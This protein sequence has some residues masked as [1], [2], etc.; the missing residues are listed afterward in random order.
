MSWLTSKFRALGDRQSWALH[1]EPSFLAP[2]SKLSNRDMDPTPPEKRTWKMVNFTTYWISDTFNVASWDQASA[3]LTLGMSAGQALACIFVGN[4][5]ISWAITATGTIGARHH[6]PFPVLNRSSFGFYL[7]YFSIIGRC[8]LACF[9]QGIQTAT[10]GE[11]VY[12]MIRAIWPSF[13]DFP[14][15]LPSSANITSANLLAY[16]IYW[17]FQFPWVLIPTHKLRWLFALKSVL[18]IICGFSM[19]IW[20]FIRAGGAGPIFL[21]PATLSGSKLAWAWLAGL[22]SVLGTYSTLSV[23]IPDFTRMA[24]APRDQYVQL[25][26]TPISFT[27]IAL[28]G[29]VVTS[30]GYILYGDYYWDPLRLMNNWDNRAATFFAAFAFAVATLGTNIGANSISAANDFTALLPRWFNIRRGQVLCAIIGAWVIIPWE[31]L[32]NFM[33][34]YTVFL[35][36]ICAI[37]VVDYWFIRGQKLDVPALYDPNGKYRSTAG[38]N[39]RAVAALVVS[40]PPNLPGLINAINPSIP[41]WGGV[42]PRALISY[43]QFFLAAV[44]YF[45]V[46]KIFPPLQTFV[47]ETITGEE[48]Y[49]STPSDERDEK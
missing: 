40:I 42:Y 35:G 43:L 23:N 25:I 31:I 37:M 34:G 44:T 2:N 29:I 41:V 10:S 49:P 6:V 7:S 19:M 5:I 32:A 46:C 22:Q 28:Q 14:N 24:R 27:I 17:A 36:P 15:H 45:I 21:Q 3:L 1:P 39:W 4:L 38:V 18:V 26:V 30:T 9:W 47:P 11:C 16:F 12:Q 33:S 48:E 20:A 8:I 13:E